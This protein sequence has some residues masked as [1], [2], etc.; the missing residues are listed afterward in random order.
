[1]LDVGS[2][3]TIIAVGSYA[4]ISGFGLDVNGWGPDE[5]DAGGDTCDPAERD[6]LRTSGTSSSVTCRF[7]NSP[8]DSGNVQ[9]YR[10]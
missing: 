7:W 1:M 6:T 4:T 5:V 2:N 8:D 9:C 3:K 10:Q